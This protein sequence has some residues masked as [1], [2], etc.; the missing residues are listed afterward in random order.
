MAETDLGVTPLESLPATRRAILQTLKKVGQARA[1]E[2]AVTLGI[3]GS[4][5][6]QH[7]TALTNDGLVAHDEVRGGRGRPKHLFHLAPAAEGLFPKTYSELTNELLDYVADADPELLEQVFERRRDR[8]I[9]GAQAR[10]AGRDLAGQVAELN[11]IL[12]EDGYLAEWIAMD[13]GSYRIVEHNC[14]ILGVASRYGQACTAEIEF[15][16]TVL[17]GAEVNRV[18]HMMAGARRC[19]YEITPTAART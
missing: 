10:L 11:A 18:E 16:R 14:A 7:L 8:R 1:D 13:D 2:L 4:A 19:A 5:M 15:I 12:D 6:R 3:T 17:P 9:E